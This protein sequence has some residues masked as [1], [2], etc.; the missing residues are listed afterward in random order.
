M[1]ISEVIRLE[2]DNKLIILHKEGVF[3]RAYEYSAF[4]FVT[5]INNYNVLH[6]YFK[7]IGQDVV[8]IGF[9]QSVFSKNELV[10]RE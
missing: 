3:W 2:K 4:C 8:Y 6:K 1:K 10:C 7:N 9:P 5:L